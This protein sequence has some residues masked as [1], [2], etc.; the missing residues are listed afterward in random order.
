MDG[1]TEETLCMELTLKHDICSVTDLKRNAKS[2]LRQLHETHRPM[3]LT[4]NGRAEAVL[5]DVAEFDRIS[6]AL[7]MLKL[8]APAEKDIAE[9]R[10]REASE[11]FRELRRQG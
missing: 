6:K 8:V 7:A 4:V 5:L 1:A 2:I 9:G 11:F 10:T 3:V